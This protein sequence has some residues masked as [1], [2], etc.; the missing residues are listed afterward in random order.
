MLCIS[1]V[2]T[3]ETCQHICSFHK[4][5][6]SEENSN[7]CFNLRILH[8]DE[9]KSA[10]QCFV[11]MVMLVTITLLYIG[12]F[13]TNACF[14]DIQNKLHSTTGQKWAQGLKTEHKSKVL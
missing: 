5:R 10:N 11:L 2:L 14:Y 8:R 6:Q 9:F 7:C 3:I 4:Q 13:S 12:L 1:A